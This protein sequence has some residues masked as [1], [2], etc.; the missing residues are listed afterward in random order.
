MNATAPAPAKPLPRPGSVGAWALAARPKTLVAGSAPVLVGS[1][2]A[3]A[4]GSFRPLLALGALVVGVSIQIGTNFVNDAADHAR[5]ADTAD[6]LGPPRAV[7]S[8]LLP[9]RVVWSAAL[10]CFVLAGGVGV[11]LA[12]VSSWWLLIPGGIAILAGIAYT[13]GPKPLA[14]L[15]LG[16]IFVFAFFGLF[17]T[18]G[19]VFVQVAGTT[20]DPLISIFAITVGCSMGFL[21]VVILEVNNI[22][23]APT[24]REAG[25]VTLAVRI[26]D[27]RARILLAAFL[28]G[29]YVFVILPL[30]PVLVI[31]IPW[32]LAPMLTIPL[33]LSAHRTLARGDSG[34]PLNLVLAKVA[35]LQAVFALLT[36][37]GFVVLGVIIR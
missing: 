33:A 7:A 4:A 32:L 22:R 26:G 3:F 29:A 8:G 27:R 28:I 11:W 18:A 30:M 16:E 14:Y 2:I 37:A 24:D 12:S 20:V 5:G 1:S 23:D 34:R 19:T 36:A 13:A 21:A 6:R 31:S 10:D 35:L 17:A 9:S 15:G 25:K